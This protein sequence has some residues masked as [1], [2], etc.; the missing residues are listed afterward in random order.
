MTY[1]DMRHKAE[2]ALGAEGQYVTFDAN[3][4]LDVLDHLES[5]EHDLKYLEAASEGLEKEKAEA[6]QRA[7][8]A[9]AKVSILKDALAKLKEKD[10]EQKPT[11][12]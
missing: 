5:V 9:E 12:F 10:A 3:E 4:V 2:Y 8:E 7:E 6:L 11:N 1:S